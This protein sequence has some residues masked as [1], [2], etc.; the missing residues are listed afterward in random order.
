MSRD[1]LAAGV[2]LLRFGTTS[3]MD[4]GDLD[5]QIQEVL[6][7]YLHVCL[8]TVHCVSN[9]SCILLPGQACKNLT[10]ASSAQL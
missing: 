7:L 3:T 4:D 1:S 6:D 10:I 9:L 2:D 8:V 5:K